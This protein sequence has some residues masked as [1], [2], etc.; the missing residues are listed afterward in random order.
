MSTI[1]ALYIWTVVGFGNGQPV[2]HWRHMGDFASEKHC[3][4]AGNKISTPGAFN[5]VDTG[6][7]Q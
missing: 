7:K 3:T 4:D 5:C 1:I 6:R 2:S